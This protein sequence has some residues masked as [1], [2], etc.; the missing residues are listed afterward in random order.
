MIDPNTEPLISLAEFGLALRFGSKL[1]SR[2]GAT[3]SDEE[4]G[5]TSYVIFRHGVQSHC[6]YCGDARFRLRSAGRCQP[7]FACEGCEHRLET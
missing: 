4:E 2:T 1:W 3:N 5:R 6:P 7:Y